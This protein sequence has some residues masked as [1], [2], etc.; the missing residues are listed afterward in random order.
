MTFT[1]RDVLIALSA[2]TGLMRCAGT[3][4][5]PAASTAFPLGVA[6]GDPT[7][8]GAVLWTRSAGEGALTALVW[9]DGAQGEALA[10]QYEV[11]AGDGGYAQVEVAGL[12][13][14][15]WYRY[16]FVASGQRDARSPSG[17]FRTAPAA[18]TR[19]VVKLGATCCT[20]YGNSFEVLGHAGARE[21]LDAFLLLGD[22]VYADGAH[23][24]DAFRACWQRS[25]STPEYQALRSS[26]GV[27]AV[28][29][30][31]EFN[32]DWSGDSIAPDR[33]SW[34]SGAW[35]DHMPMRRHPTNPERIWRS[36]RFG[37]TV[38][39]FALDSRSERVRSQGQYLSEAQLAWLEEGLRTSTATFKVLMNSVPI[40]S[41]TVPFFSTTAH[42]R[43]ESFPQARARVLEFIDAERI[44]GVLWLSGDFHLA[45]AGKVGLDGPGKDAVEVLVG[46][47][48][49]TPNAAPSYPGLP[50]FEWSSGIN[51]Y[52]ELTLDPSTGV[53]KV[54]WIRG[55]GRRIF[56]RSYQLA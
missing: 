4:L 32:N 42:D 3:P 38:E 48:A 47:G 29:D 45:C 22:T 53:A 5:V 30:D 51:N 18:G 56:S 20:Q 11:R 52:G 19:D 9:A 36:F 40:S 33:F 54:A 37:D 50:Q 39:L 46:P 31:H 21:D 28:W 14:G 13:P 26:T 6:A 16:A 43:W 8:D 15:T 23:D 27:I 25:F 12:R 24:P 44:P 1:R 34:A 55:N 35:F 17:R 10:T 2:S 49:Q 7:S 41:F